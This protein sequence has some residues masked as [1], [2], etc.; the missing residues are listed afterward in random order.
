M[1]E[2]DQEI[3]IMSIIAKTISELEDGEDRA[4]VIRWVAAKFGV[5]LSTTV[6]ALHPSLGDVKEQA[7]ESGLP[8]SQFTNF[9]DL[10]D[11]VNPGTDI[12]SALTGSYWFQVI[13]NCPSW[14]SYQV[15]NI[16]KDT[17]HGIGSITHALDAAQKKTPA[18]VRQITKSGKSKQSR[19]TYKLTTSGVDFISKRIHAP[20]NPSDKEIAVT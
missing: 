15:N 9:V 3:K 12:E 19:K 14:T 11:V 20:S 13:K 6:P 18:L 1:E 7:T 10:F 17:G 4:R 5:S 8:P 16:L 2:I